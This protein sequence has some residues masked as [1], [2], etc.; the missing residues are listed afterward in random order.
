MLF[1]QVIVNA[2]LKSI[3]DWHRNQLFLTTEISYADLL[4]QFL[5]SKNC[6]DGLLSAIQNVLNANDHCRAIGLLV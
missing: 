2:S 4:Y 5:F 1:V 3:V 6:Y